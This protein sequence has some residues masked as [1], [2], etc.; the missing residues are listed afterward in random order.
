MPQQVLNSVD[1]RQ[2]ERIGTI[3]ECIDYT[4]P[5][6]GYFSGASMPN[7]WVRRVVF[8]IQFDESDTVVIDEVMDATSALLRK[9]DR[10]RVSLDDGQDQ[11]TVRPIADWRLASDQSVDTI[12]GATVLRGG[13]FFDLRGLHSKASLLQVSGIQVPFIYVR[14][15]APNTSAAAGINPHRDLDGRIGTV[16]ARKHYLHFHR[17]PYN[18]SR[19]PVRKVFRVAF[20][21]RFVRGC[22]AELISIDQAI[23]P[24][25]ASIEKGDKVT[26]RASHDPLLESSMQL[27]TGPLAAT[28]NWLNRRYRRWFHA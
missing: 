13:E 26:V 7:R 4:V 20:I 12:C 14:G 22:R 9:R 2:V 3:V 1:E 21:V 10:V 24:V 23:N 25:T 16:V 18:S 5:H 19:T 6:R 11:A 15:L 17:Q 28:H 27:A 8:M